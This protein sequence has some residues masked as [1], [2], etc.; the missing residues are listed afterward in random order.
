MVQYKLIS[1]AEEMADAMTRTAISSL[2]NQA[3]DFSTAILDA[4]GRSVA[5]ADRVPIHL[6]AMPSSV[7]SAISY[8]TGDIHDG[9]VIA[10]NDPY[11]GGSH[12]PDITF[13]RPI[14]VGGSPA[15]FVANRAH[16]GD[17]GGAAH[18]GYNAEAVEIFQEGLRIPPVKVVSR[19][20]VREDLLNLIAVNTRTPEDIRGDLEA[21][22]ASVAVGARRLE[23]FLEEMGGGL[24]HEC[25]S[26]ILDGTER[27]VRAEVARWKDGV[28]RG[29]SLLDDDGHG[30][31]DIPIRV[32]LTVHGDD[33]EVDLAESSPQVSS[34]INSP[35]A[36]TIS[37]VGVAVI[38]LCSGEVPV[39]SGCLRP[40]RII[41]RKG[42]IVDPRPPA[43]V[44][45]CTTHCASE[46]IEAVLQAAAQ[47]VPGKS[48]AG[49]A[50]RFRYAVSG[51]Q[52]RTGRPYVWHL[53]HGR[54]GGGACWGSDGWSNMGVIINPGGVRSPSIER[55]ELE[56]P[57][58]VRRYEF[59]TDSAGAGRWRGGSGS[60]FEMEM[61]GDEPAFLNSAGD[62]TVHAPYGLLGGRPGQPHSFSVCAGGAMRPL[63][64]KEVGVRLGPGDWVR[65]HSAGG[66]GM[67]D[68]RERPRRDVERDVRDGFISP[69]AA[70]DV[71]GYT[72][73]CP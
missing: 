27:I 14:F 51:K 7:A 32:Q 73:A 23:A 29:E 3:L 69:E 33:L 71:Y 64:T 40:I 42:T 56:F 48:I 10:L 22:L 47:A 19:G 45:A 60:V 2:L 37:A 67:G 18:G 43:P 35:L 52:P 63:S 55:T 68:P 70:R 46:I 30:S 28:Y 49:Y 66:G 59:R 34:F 65:N 24:V 1:I 25:V 31:R 11:W 6:G 58:W 44:G 8:F 9:D 20:Q 41:T 61:R 21:Q 50:R 26:R 12:L 13:V 72:G 53:F 38:Y 57:F 54:G 39:N 16:H 62:G 36:N 17:I 4:G 15:F 5:Q